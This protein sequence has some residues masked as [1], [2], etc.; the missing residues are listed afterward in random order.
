MRSWWWINRHHCQKILFIKLHIAHSNILTKQ[1][2]TRQNRLFLLHRFS[3]VTAKKNNANAY[4][5]GT[6]HQKYN[7]NVHQS[8]RHTRNTTQTPTKTERHTEIQRTRV[9]NP[10]V[11]PEIHVQ[12]KRLPNPNRQRNLY[13][14]VKLNSMTSIQWRLRTC[15]TLK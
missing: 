10:K 5:T 3:V 7:K 13:C 11:T 15:W 14:K 8:D 6:A 12:R 2:V 1:N 4:Q 9:Q